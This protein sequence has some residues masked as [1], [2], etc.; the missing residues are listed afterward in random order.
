M[1]SAACGHRARAFRGGA[2]DWRWRRRWPLALVLDTA[3]GRL[4]RLQGTSSAF[5][6][7]LDQVL[8]ELADMALHAA[9]AWAAFCRDG[10]AGLAAAW[11]CSTHHGSICFMFSRCW[12]TS[13]RGRWNKKGPPAGRVPAG[14]RPG[15]ARAAR[16][17]GSQRL[18]RLIGHADL[19]WHLWIVLAIFG[20]LEL[21]LLV[22]AFYFPVRAAASALK[23]GVRYA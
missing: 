7:W 15:F 1:L 19:R 4:A 9:I 6:R 10:R 11:E 16:C 17:G 18:V 2:A 22:Y 14:A 23:K 13:S 12:V 21:A 5:G 20:R 8:D 3:D